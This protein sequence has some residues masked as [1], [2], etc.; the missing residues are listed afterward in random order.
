[1]HEHKH[2][3]ARDIEPQHK[4][5]HPG[6]HEQYEYLIRP[7]VGPDEADHCEVNVYTLPPGRSNYPY[8]YHTMTEEVFY[9][10]SGSGVARTATGDES[11]S[12]GDLLFWPAHELGA[13]KLT[14]TS[15]T[16]DLVYVDFD[17][18]VPVNVAVYPDSKKLGI[19][20]DG[21]DRCYRI[22]D[23][24]RFFEGEA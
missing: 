4:G 17:T 16:E 8:H 6:H 2:V 9:I 10:V 12:A 20:G 3:N 22:D 19:W 23:N 18:A 15:E 5:G 21:I 7:F 1:M 14:N 11:V 13:H 24:V